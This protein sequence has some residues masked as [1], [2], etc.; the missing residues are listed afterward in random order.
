M[1][2]SNVVRSRDKSVEALNRRQQAF[3]AFIAREFSQFERLAMKTDNAIVSQ[4]TERAVHRADSISGRDRERKRAR[5]RAREMKR[6]RRQ[7]KE[8][9]ADSDWRKRARERDVDSD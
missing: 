1:Q 7:A 8:R 6:R 2:D 3:E 9:D 5:E 4:K